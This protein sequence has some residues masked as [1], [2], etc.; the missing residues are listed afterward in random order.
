MNRNTEIEILLV[1]DSPYDAELTLRTLREH[2]LANAVVHV[3]DGQEALDWLFGTDG[4]PG[5]NRAG[6]PKVILLDLK[7]PKVDGLEV[8]RSI[9]ANP[10]TELLPVVVMTSSGEERDIVESY[11]LG[12]NSYVIK[13]L[14]FDSFSTAVAQLGH[15]WLLV[16]QDP[17]MRG[18]GEND[19]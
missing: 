9:R 8:L 3:K 12:A 11:R 4:N 14:D 19:E 6:H 18:E 7:L 17:G 13:P 2:K 10:L 5:C 16:N 15:Y 1:E